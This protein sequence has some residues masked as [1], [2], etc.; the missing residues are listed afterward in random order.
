[1][2]SLK[3][4]INHRDPL[5]GDFQLEDKAKFRSIFETFHVEMFHWRMRQPPAFRQNYTS[6]WC[7]CNQLIIDVINERL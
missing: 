1:M 5:Y 3:H 4:S 6:L 7:L 2:T